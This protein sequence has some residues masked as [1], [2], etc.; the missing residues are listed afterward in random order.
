MRIF[1]NPN[2]DFIRWRWHALALSVAIVVAGVFAVV[3]RGGIP[4][5][6]DFSGGTVIWLRFAQPTN[7]QTVRE[8][9][10]ALS[11]EATV[12]TF[13]R[14][15]DNEILIRLPI[16]HEVEQGTNLDQDAR[17]VEESLR[18]AKVGSFE[19]LNSDIVGPTVGADL[20]RRGIL[21]TLFALVGIM[22][23][24]ALRFRFSFGVGA[25]IASFHDV[26]VTLSI[27][28]LA[29][30][31]LSLNVIAAILTLVGYGVNDQIVVFD[32]VRENMRVSRREPMR[33][34]INRAVN[35]TLPRTVI[36]AGATALS[37]LALYL[38]G[39]DVLES[40]AFT[41]LVGIVSSTYSTVYIASAVAILL[42]KRAPLPASQGA[43]AA[44]VRRRRA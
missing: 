6:V 25:A 22:T 4:L 26:F 21:A 9:L 18:G 44:E 32:R 3:S 31:E 27:L 8:A 24:I 19:V 10:G 7:E 17:R 40:F 5:G 28:T 41:M 2:F 33:D 30:Y 12:Q 15:G 20:Q 11:G 16:R 43:R 36:T 34:I 23:Y 13:G 39:G 35:Q 14:P 37:V 38:F 1:A 42:S 29:G